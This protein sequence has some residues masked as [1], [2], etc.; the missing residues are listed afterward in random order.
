MRAAIAGAF[1]TVG[2]DGHEQ[3]LVRV[4]AS[5]GVA[6]APAHGR[7]VADLL[8]AADRAMYAAKEAG[9]DRVRTAAT[10]PG[11]DQWHEPA[12]PAA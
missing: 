4:T 5:I 1:A 12:T 10:P 6:G 7:S 11:A 9:R 3:L 8:A 2:T